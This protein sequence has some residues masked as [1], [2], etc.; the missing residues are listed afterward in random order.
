MGDSNSELTLGPRWLYPAKALATRTRS[1]AF[2]WRTR[3][4]APAPGVRILFYH[5][6]TDERDELAVSPRAFAA[7]MAELAERGYRGVHVGEVASVIRAGTDSGRVVGISFDD[8]YAD[9]AEHA[10]PVLAEHGF[11]ATVFVATAVTDGRV[12]LAWYREQPPLISWD[13]MR[14]L[15]RSSPLRFEAHTVTHPNLLELG[16]EAARLEI[17]SCRAELADRLGRD[18]DGFCYPAGLY[19]S[20]ERRLVAAAGYAWAATCEPGPNRAGDDVFALRRIQVDARD[21]L[22]DFRAKLLGGHDR[23]LPLRRLYRRA[24][25]GQPEAAD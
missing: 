14:A 15:D 3:H 8:G 20:R 4:R 16:D 6:V 22:L 7:H 25:F 1:T 23:P 18:V 17:E 11:T 9:V 13:A 2:L 10:A 19:G 24:R 21:S 12:P 5:R